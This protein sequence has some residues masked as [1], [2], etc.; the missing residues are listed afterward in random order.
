M[1]GRVRFETGSWLKGGSWKHLCRSVTS[2]KT[3]LISNLPFDLPFDS[4][5]TLQSERSG[6][7][8]VSAVSD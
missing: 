5:V 1:K 8:K 6:S 4:H 7:N 2:D 3:T